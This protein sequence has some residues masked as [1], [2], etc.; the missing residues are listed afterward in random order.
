MTP[1]QLALLS[2][3]RAVMIESR[4]ESKFS[5]AMP[6]KRNGVRV[7]V[8]DATLS[9]GENFL[10]PIVPGGRDPESS[11]NCLVARFPNPILYK[12]EKVVAEGVTVEV[13]ESLNL[14]KV[15]VT[16]G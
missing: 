7:Y 11:S 9:H 3:P 16:K 4:R 2:N 12:G 15:R 1:A 13:L 5:C 14:D 8:Y 10:R 6:S